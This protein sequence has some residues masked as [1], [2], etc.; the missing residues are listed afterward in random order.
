V[1]Y[2]SLLRRSLHDA[3]LRKPTTSRI[4]LDGAAIEQV[5]KPGVCKNFREYAQEIFIS[6][7]STRFKSSSR[8]RVGCATP[9]STAKY[10]KEVC[11]CVVAE[12]TV[13]RNWQNFL[14][15]NTNETQLLKFIRSSSPVV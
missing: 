12:A 8:H 14:R 3:S 7:V 15:V 5:L 13:P 6:Y 1:T 10:G 9:S 4:V 11:G 2:L